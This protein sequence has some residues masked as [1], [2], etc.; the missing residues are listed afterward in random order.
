MN[1]DVNKILD[2]ISSE[3]ANDMATVKKRI[4]VLQEEN[5]RLKEQVKQLQG[6][7]KNKEEKEEEDAD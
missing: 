2:I 4:S 6:Q 5:G 3:W 1:Q 7:L